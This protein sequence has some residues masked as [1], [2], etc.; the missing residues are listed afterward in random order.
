M[1]FRSE[2]LGV[3]DVPTTP[4]A[5]GD[6]QLRVAPN[7]S[8]GSSFVTWSGATG[9]LRFDVLDERGR[10]VA[11]GRGEASAEGRWLWR[12]THDDGRPLPAGVYFVRARDDAGHA[13]TERVVLVK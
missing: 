7:P 11:E 5:R 4:P 12:G 10:R 1:L 8:R 2:P 9:P 3:L 13:A 6:L